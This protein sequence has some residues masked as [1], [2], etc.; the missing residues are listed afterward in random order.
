MKSITVEPV[1][2]LYMFT[3]FL[4]F[5]T[6][7]ALV[8][9]KVCNER[10][11]ATVCANLDNE[12]YKAQEKV[13]QKTTSSWLMYSNLAMGIPS[14]FTVVLFLGPWGDR[15]GRKL[16]VLSPL[17]GALFASVCNMINSVYMDASLSYLLIGNVLNG[18]MGGYIAALMAM[19]SYIAHVST[20]TYRTIKIGI[21]ESM[22]F[23]SGT[24]GTALSGVILDHT[25][26]VFVFS[27]LAGIM[28]LALMYTLVWVDNIKPE[29]TLDGNSDSE[30]CCKSLILDSVK[31]VFV[32]VYDKRR[33]KN[34][35]H[36]ALSITILFFMML[37]TVGKHNIVCTQ[38]AWARSR[39]A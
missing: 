13:V 7:Q 22:I 14:L 29:N 17:I 34:F 23:L 5:I 26:Y 21:L 2:F 11:N 30:G 19:Y 10:F 12:T 3:T 8:Y 18:L 28:L 33:S 39:R 9:E 38:T 31:D 25:S 35:L 15:V 27:L 32:C 20:P 4:M 16:P 6:F 24:V 36:L 37:V 1:M